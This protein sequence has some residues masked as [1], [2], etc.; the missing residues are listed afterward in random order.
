MTMHSLNSFINHLAEMAGHVLVAE[1]QALKKA[2]EIV[3][4]E[5]KS[6]IGEYQ[7]AI[8]T[9]SAWEQLASATQEDRVSKGYSANNPLLR[10]GTLRDSISHEV[11]GLTAAIGSTSDIM[12]YQELGTEKIPPRAV[13]GPSLMRKRKQVLQLVGV[14]TAGAMLHGSAISHMPTITED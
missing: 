1:H 14:Y 2:A 12:V 3:E 5:A 11:H 8:G 4:K 13:L 10:D 6:E 7:G 9:F